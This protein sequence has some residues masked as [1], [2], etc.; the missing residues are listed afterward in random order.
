MHDEENDEL[1]PEDEDEVA[2]RATTKLAVRSR[3]TIFAKRLMASRRSMPT[4]TKGKR[5][6]KKKV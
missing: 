6:G 4:K 3:R 1:E 2:G 5:R